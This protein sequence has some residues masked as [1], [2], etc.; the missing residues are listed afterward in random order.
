MNIAITLL[1]KLIDKNPTTSKKTC[2]TQ[3]S[4]KYVDSVSINHPK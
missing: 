1:P 4:I 3:I 2:R